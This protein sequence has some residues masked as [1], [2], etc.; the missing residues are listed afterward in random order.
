[1]MKG[2]N[3]RAKLFI[4][5][6]ASSLVLGLAARSASPEQKQDKNAPAASRSNEDRS[7]GKPSSSRLLDINLA[8]KDELKELS[9]IGDVMAEKIIAGRPYRSKRDLLTRKIIPASTYNSISDRIVA[10]QS[11]QNVTAAGHSTRSDAGARTDSK[12]P[13]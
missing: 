7:Q 5:I 1:M 2:I 12:A 3:R 9:G 13:R 11:R 8:N 6:L 4:S 10:R